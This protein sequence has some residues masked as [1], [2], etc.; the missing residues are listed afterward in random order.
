MKTKEATLVEKVGLDAAVFMRFT[1]MMRNMFL[2]LALIGNAVLIPAN[3]L[4]ADSTASSGASFFTRL[5]PVYS[6]GSAFWAYVVLA[7]LFNAVIFYFLWANYRAILRLRRAYLDS[8]EYQRSLHSRTLLLTDIPA[9]LRSDEGIVRITDEVKASADVPRGQIARNVKDLPDLVEEHEEAVKELEKHLAKYLKNPDKIPAKRPTTK[10]SKAHGNFA[11]GQEVDAIEY[12]TVRIKELE[13]EVKEVRLSVDNRNAMSYGFAVYERI[14]EAHNVAY[15]ARNKAPQGSI[16]RLAPKPHDLIW[17]NLPMMKKERKW[18]NFI[19]NLWVALL[20]LAW[21]APNV[22][23]AVFLS[24][25][26]HLASVWPA[27]KTS[28]LKYPTF[29]AI[30]QGVVAPAITTLFYYFLPAIFRRLVTNAGDVTKTQ[31]E[32]HVMH[33]L[34]S[35]FLFNNLIVFSLFGAVWGLITAIIGSTKGADS[36]NGWEAIVKSH[37]FQNI[38]T[39]LITLT[40]YWASWL[41]QRNLGAAIDLSQLV[42][43]T[44]GSFS[45]RYLSPTPRELIELTAPQPF[46]YAAYYNYFLFYTAVTLT[47]GALQPLILAITALYFCFDSFSKKYMIMYI[48]ITKYESGGMFWRTLFNRTLVSAALG[49]IVIALLVVAKG[50]YGTVNWGMLAAMAPLP[51]LIGAFKWYCM[52]AFDDGI[53]YYHHGQTMR[54]EEVHAGEGKRRKGDRISSKFG[55]PALYKPLMTPMVSAKSQ[56][57]LKQIYTGRTSIDDSGRAAGFTDVYMDAMDARQPG[58]PSSSGPAAAAAAPFEIVND[59]QLDFAHWKDSPHFR[60]QAGGDGQLYGQPADLSRPG[61]PGSFMT[62]TATWDSSRERSQS[63]GDPYSQSHSRVVSDDSDATRV[64]EGG[65]GVEYPHGYHKTPSSA[66]REHSPDGNSES[67]FS[68]PVTR[69]QESREGLISAAGRMGRSPPPQLPT[70]GAVGYGQGG[71]GQAGY[72]QIR[73]TPGETPPTGTPGSEGGSYVSFF[74]LSFLITLSVANE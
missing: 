55:H 58:K 64:N 15:V 12:L 49:N 74:S 17:K 25:L 69:R 34:F 27:F 40:P 20:T 71:Y 41:L 11:K 70:P 54:D 50:G 52:K 67:A 2:V 10:V 73:L 33:K 72:G 36:V 61:T 66:L 68:R 8:D 42:R 37:P 46:E 35:F 39:T 18:Q 53:H 38:V 5:T 16:I 4:A 32:R 31:R 60:D 7:Y 62:R 28:L 59:H 47:F 45:R 13:T 57:M 43:L 44:W 3:M 19:N 23:I 30:V 51:F 56:H 14:G 29:W 22:L 48:F 9:Q 63:R 1:R 21:V 6:Y 24:N 65:V 26:S